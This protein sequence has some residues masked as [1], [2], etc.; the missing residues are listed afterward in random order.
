[1][2]TIGDAFA[3]TIHARPELWLWL[4]RRWY[5]LEQNDEVAKVVHGTP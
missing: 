1:M 4:H 2:Q 3:P 5:V